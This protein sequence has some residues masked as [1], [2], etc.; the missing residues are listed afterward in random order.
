MNWRQLTAFGHDVVA[1]MLAWV[2]AFWLRFNL[3]IPEPFGEIAVKSAMWVVPLY[4]ALFL[5]FGLYR[6]LWRFASLPD[7]KRIIAAVAVG[8]IA[9]PTGPGLGVRLDDASLR[10]AAPVEAA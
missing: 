5:G 3:E 1:T 10:A 7:M 4:G 2:I 8:A 6:G 9:V